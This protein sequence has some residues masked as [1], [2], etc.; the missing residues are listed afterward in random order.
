MTAD[1]EEAGRY[2]HIPKLRIRR[3]R[4]S[5]KTRAHETEDIPAGTLENPA[6]ELDSA[7]AWSESML[8]ALT[9]QSGGELRV[10]VVVA[11]VTDKQRRLANCFPE[12]A[13]VD[14]QFGTNHEKRNLL[15]LMVKT[16]ENKISGT[17]QYLMP[18]GARWATNF[19]AIKAIPSFLGPHFCRKLNALATDGEQK[20]YGPFVDQMTPRG[21]FPNCKHFLCIWHL[22]YRS[23]DQPNINPGK[24]TRLQSVYHEVFRQFLISLSSVPETREKYDMMEMYFVDWLKSGP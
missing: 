11:W 7:K 6:A 9:C 12:A 21:I 13:G 19:A 15:M 5:P 10:L 4:V 3:T 24:Y 1:R 2:V 22:A 18:S 17:F 20:L 16:A 8:N 14:V 23:K